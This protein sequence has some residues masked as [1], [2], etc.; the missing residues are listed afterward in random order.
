MLVGTLKTWSNFSNVFPLVSGSSV[1]I[2]KKPTMFHPAYQENAPCGV[3]ADYIP[4]HVMDSTALKD[5]V[6][7]VASDIP[8]ART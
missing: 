8:Y 2:R 4:G 6:V 3:N 1:K 7:A 5:H